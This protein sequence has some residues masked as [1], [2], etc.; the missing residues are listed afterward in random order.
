MPSTFDIKK[1]HVRLGIRRSLDLTGETIEPYMGPTARSAE[2]IASITEGSNEPEVGDPDEPDELR[3]TVVME[4]L[5]K[6]ADVAPI[7]QGWDHMEKWSTRLFFELMVS[8]E[9][10]RGED[11]RQ[12]WFENQITFLESYL[13]PLARRLHATRAFGNIVGPMFARTVEENRDHWIADG[14]VLTAEVTQKWIRRNQSSD[15][16]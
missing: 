7:M 10:G 14:V 3:A 6:A 16:I 4:Q 11:P 13:L 12:G 2:S 9:A 15:S 5:I 1:A 8:Y